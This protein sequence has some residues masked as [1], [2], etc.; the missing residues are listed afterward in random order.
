MNQTEWEDRLKTLLKK[1]GEDFKKVG[2][3]IKTQ[4][5]QLLSQAKDPETQK[6]VR[7][8][9]TEVGD[10]AKKTG[11]ELAGMVDQGL[12]KAE[13]TFTQTRGS[14]AAAPSAAPKEKPSKPSTVGAPDEV[15]EVKPAKK[16]VG[17]GAKK[18]KKSAP[19]KDTKKT[20][21]KSPADTTDED[22]PGGE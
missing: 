11:Q 20:I 22:V 7:E 8:K 14:A 15:R 18:K 13:T 6:K 10:W 3:D 4:A 17:R 16:T 9:L 19:P 5:Q 21:G 2:N 1:T 12:K